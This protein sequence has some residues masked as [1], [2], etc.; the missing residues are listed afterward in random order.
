[1][2]KSPF[3][4]DIQ[5]QAQALRSFEPSILPA[6]LT[7]LARARPE[8]IVLTGMGSSH[9]AAVPTWRRLVAAGHPVWWVDT[10]QLLDSP[11]LL[12]P[13][14][15]LVITSQSGASGEIA[16]LLDPEAA[17]TSGCTVVG[18]TNDPDSPLGRAADI[19]VELHSGPE[20]TVSTKSY[21]NTLAAH[22]RVLDTLL[23]SP[24]P[25]STLDV[26]KHL[27]SW[28]APAALIDAAHAAADT[29]TSRIAFIGAADHAATALYAGLITKE[30]AKVAAEGYI[31]SQF[32]HGPMELAGTGLTAILFGATTTGGDPLPRLARDLVATGST[33][34][35][36]GDLDIDGGDRIHVPTGDILTELSVGA[37][38]AQT[39]AVEVA[40]ARGIVPGAFRYGSKIT[41]AL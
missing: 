7:S 28:T 23:G 13:T 38:V 4:I 22:Q 32:R 20:A 40:R 3:E 8:R 29:P 21:L 31:G 5:D 24:R 1:M 39:F 9:F 14:T 12:T 35:L 17:L 15:L 34:L 27:E 37:L 41:S 30:A 2:S 11:D 6:H 19:L 33:V 26:A 36:V 16:A 10:G 25:T 18:I